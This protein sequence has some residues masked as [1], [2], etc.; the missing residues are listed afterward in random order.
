MC[1]VEQWKEESGRAEERLRALFVASDVDGDGNL[2]FNE[3]T[4]IINHLRGGKGHREMLRMYAEMTLNKQVD[5]NTFVRVC[6]QYRFFTFEVGPVTRK[7][8]PAAKEIFETLEDEWGKFELTAMELLTI[9]A[10]TAAANRL[11]QLVLVFKKKMNE[12]SDPEETWH[13]LRHIVEEMTAIVRKR[14][15]EYPSFFQG[16]HLK[17]AKKD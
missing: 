16:M 7:A 15:V 1:L 2:D 9:M 17:N 4:S 13:I 6:R 5:C 11:E 10:G 14:A 8:D 12:K 3:F